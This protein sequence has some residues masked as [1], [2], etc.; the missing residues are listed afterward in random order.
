VARDNRDADG[1][2]GARETPPLTR[3]A[4]AVSPAAMS[5]YGPS[6]YGDRAAA[7]YDE[8]FTHPSASEACIDLL[9]ELAGKGPA[10]E[11]GI[12]TGRVALPLAARGVEIRG[13]DSSRRMV[14]KMRAK[15]GGRRIPVT[16]GDFAGV[17]VKGSYSLVFVVFNTFFGLLTQDDQVRC[18]ENV[19]KRLAPGGAFLIEAFVPDLTRFD[20][21][22]RM[23][24]VHVDTESDLVQFHASAH[25]AALQ[26]VHTQQFVAER[27][28]LSMSPL[29]IRYAWPSELDLMARI[30]GLRLRERWSGWGRTPFTSASGAHVSVYER[31]R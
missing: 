6:T 18:F 2:F 1:R 29:R 13:I 19:A 25:L 16:F 31:V 22:Q 4:R 14:A 8:L 26:Q 9:A 23:D 27:G 20:R 30:A 21:G 11:L 15:K 5:R 3:A 28:K 7:R 17:P 10:L 24:A 12:G